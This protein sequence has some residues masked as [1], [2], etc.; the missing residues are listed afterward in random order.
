MLLMVLKGKF[1][2]DCRSVTRNEIVSLIRKKKAISVYDIKL[3]TLASTGC[4]R[5]KTEVEKIVGDELKRL[6]E[7]N[8]Q[9][10]IDFNE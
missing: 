10:S 9:L 2:C 3:I 6:R 4:G 7:N 1:V 8:R 5:C